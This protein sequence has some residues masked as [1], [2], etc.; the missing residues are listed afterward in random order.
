[1]KVKHKLSVISVLAVIAV[2]CLCA[3]VISAC[4]G[5]KDHMHA[6]STD[7][8]YDET[9]HW[10]YCTVYD[11][12][13]ETSGKAE[14][15]YDY[16]NPTASD[17]GYVYTCTECGYQTT[18]STEIYSITL[19]NIGGTPLTGVSIELR[20][21]SGSK[22]SSGTTNSSGILR[23]RNLTSGTYVAYIDESTLPTGYSLDSDQV[24]LT[25]TDKNVTV[26][27]N[28]AVITDEQMPSSKVYSV[29]DVVYD[30]TITCYNTDETT[31][32]VKLSEY[33]EKYDVVFLNF[34][35]TTC[36]PCG[37]EVPY[38]E[39][40]YED[41]EGKVGLI[42]F[43]Y[44]GLGDT[45]AKMIEFKSS[46]GLS[47][48]FTLD[49]SSYYSNYGVTG[50][51]TTVIIDRYGIIA[52]I[53]TGSNESA[54]SWINMFEYYISDNYEPSYTT[55]KRD[56]TTDTQVESDVTM[57]DS[58]DIAAAIVTTNDYT[59]ASTF[60][61]SNY[62]EDGVEDV[63]NWPWIIGEE[64]VS[65]VSDYIMTSNAG[66]VGGYSIIVIDVTLKA[67][68]TILFDYFVSTEEEY[69]IFYVQVDGVLQLE[70]SGL[71]T[72][73]Q[74]CLAY[75]AVYDGDYQLTLYYQKD[76]S[77]N[78]NDDAVYVSN[79]RIGTTADIASDSSIC[80]DILYSA[81]TN[82]ADSSVD[83]SGYGEGYGYYNYVDVYLASDGYY[84]VGS[85]TEGSDP[86]DDPYLLADLYYGTPW[87]SSM[88]VWYEVYAFADEIDEKLGDGTYDAFEDYV[89]TQNNCPWNYVPVNV[90]LHDMLVAF[91]A[92]YGRTTGDLLDV[93]WLEVCRYFVHYGSE[94]ADG[95]KCYST[96][97]IAETYG[98]R[99]AKDLG[100]ISSTANTDDDTAYVFTAE[101]ETLLVPR[102]NYYTFTVDKSGVYRVYSY[103]FLTDADAAPYAFISGSG[104]SASSEQDDL[105]NEEGFQRDG[106]DSSVVSYDFGMY[107]YLTAGETYYLGCTFA[108]TEETGSYRVGIYYIGD[109]LRYLATLTTG[110]VYTYYE[111]TDADGNVTDYVYY[112]PTRLNRTS[113]A[114]NP[115]DNCWYTLDENRDYDQLIYIDM[116]GSTWWNYYSSY[117][118]EEAIAANAG[119]WSDTE[120]SILNHYLDLAKNNTDTADV[121]AGTSSMYGLTAA[122]SELVTIINALCN[123]GDDETS[124]TFAENAWMLTAYYIRVVN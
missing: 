55:N 16:D 111:V 12:C 119:D 50:F 6:Y 116:V 30:F 53:E 36:G 44:T 57:P 19:T 48:D 84:H 92:E 101:I 88:S 94:H 103:D 25:A 66:I 107:V 75:V 27:A 121:T 77:K 71:S 14:H 8:K 15:T 64:K 40:A 113:Y 86:G 81:A 117:T 17:D 56:D 26:K 35:Y 32:T 4:G 90:E 82:Y 23:F 28:S 104:V 52:E 60:T 68:Q 79:L 95:D 100:T 124:S 63:Y 62:S 78:V 96:D 37:R 33:L 97:N 24:T 39:Q 54:A 76:S 87:Y 80:A 9:Y 11:N 2:T 93:Q 74:T 47:F 102:G 99:Y 98:I 91:V 21:S 41:Y 38:M 106:Y 31:Y 46:Y 73:W 120:L 105:A 29:G 34:F 89:W 108:S 51:P 109:E 18:E 69:D 49:S 70:T 43:D 45:V 118:I 114:L 123:G 72:S 1:M 122:T 83:V 20:S 59:T 58:E 112:L 13:E 61:F 115:D 110:S 3:A 7:W 10:H 22:V 65:G 67:G 85:K 42:A 5:V